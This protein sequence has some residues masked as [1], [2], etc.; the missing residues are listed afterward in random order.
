MGYRKRNFPYISYYFHIPKIFDYFFFFF[1]KNRNR[2]RFFFLFFI[3]F[4]AT[5][6][7]KSFAVGQEGSPDIL[8]A[9]V[10]AAQLGT[11]HI[12]MLFTPEMAFEG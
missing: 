8:A 3:S 12:E 10:V 6:K 11:E 1:G 5:D 7:I 4:T 2:N 9:R